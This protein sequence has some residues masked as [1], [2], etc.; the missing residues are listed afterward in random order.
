MSTPTN[1]VALPGSER[2]PLPGARAGEAADPAERILVTVIVRRKAP[3]REAGADSLPFT[4]NRLRRE[5]FAA[6]YGGQPEDMAA[7]AS[8]ARSSG[9]TVVESHLARRSIILSGTVAAFSAAFGV[10]LSRYDHAGG[11]YRGLTGPVYVPA[12]LAPVIAGVFGLDDRPQAE[13]HFQLATESEPREGITFT[14]AQVAR[15]Y[16]FPEGTG[17][18]QTIGIIELGG[19]FRTEDVQAYFSELGIPVPSV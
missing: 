8:Y 6:R 11:T 2:G 18:G 1:W 9:L 17:R 5:D 4:Q 15:L 14:P 12:E 19:G 10:E 3:A 16:D 13:P 7:V